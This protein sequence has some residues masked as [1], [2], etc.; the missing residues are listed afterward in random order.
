M[1][2][3]PTYEELEQKI[4]ELQKDALE[5]KRG[6]EALQE[7]EE[8]FRLAFENAVDA[9]YWANPEIGLIT[10][11]NKAAETLLEKRRDEIIG[12]HQ[13]RIHPPQKA[14][15]YSNMFRRHIERKGSVDDEAEVITK[16]GKIIPVHITASVTL[17]G[18]KPIIQGIFR[19]ITERKRAEQELRERQERYRAVLEACPDP[20]VVYDMEGKCSYINTA[21]TTVFGWTPEELIDKRLDYVPEENWPETQ[22]I[23]DR[24]LAGE[25]FSRLESRRYTKDGDIL[26]VSISAA[27]HL[28]RD[29]IPMGSVHFLRDITERKRTEK[30]LEQRKEELQAQAHSLNE[31]N[32]ALKVLLRRREEDKAELE[33]KVLS[34]VKELVMPYVERLQKSRLGATEKAYVSIIKSNLTEIVSPFLQALSLK[35]LSLTP[36]EIQTAD[37]IRL[38]KTTKEIA[39]VLNVSTRAVEFHRENIRSKLG[40]KNKKAN[41]RT[42]LL[43]LE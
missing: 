26:D 37:L 36:R 14:E 32:T 41:L 10:D 2:D 12:Q 17:V 28:R 42:H 38:G 20:V 35:H 6:E 31:A 4:K 16:S 18:G 27:I 23:I 5:R 40:L 33:G 34:N 11:C 3:K 25:S 19:D 22:L 13:T 30:A 15:Y 21:F 29:G 9:I 39:E 43:S 7:S 1:D 8:K 24:V